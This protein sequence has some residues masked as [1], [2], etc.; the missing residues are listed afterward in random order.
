MNNAPS[1]NSNKWVQVAWIA[2]F[3]V[4][5]LL[6]VLIR[7]PMAGASSWDCRHNSTCGRVVNYSSGPIT[8]SADYTVG[9]KRPSQILRYA[10]TSSFDV[11]DV[12]SSSPACMERGRT[13]TGAKL[14]PVPIHG[15]TSVKVTKTKPGVWTPV[16]DWGGCR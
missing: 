3:T 5:M 8:V 7:P 12:Y 1:L 16:R 4:L 6:V 2:L 14:S 15:G 9:G 10:Q 11:R 13:V